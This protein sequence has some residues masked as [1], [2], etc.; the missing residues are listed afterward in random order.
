M[1]TKEFTFGTTPLSTQIDEDGVVWFSANDVCGA[2]GYTNPWKATGDHV[3]ED[4]VTK[5]N[6]IDNMGRNQVASFIN[7]S[8]MYALIFG[9]Q[10]A[11][12]K[13]FKRW[14]TAEVLPAIRKDGG[15]VSRTATTE[16]LTKLSRE[17]ATIREENQTLSHALAHQRA[18]N[19]ALD[20]E[21]R[22]KCSQN[23][24]LALAIEEVPGE[25]LHNDCGPY[26]NECVYSDKFMS[27]LRQVKSEKAQKYFMK[28][29]RTLDTLHTEH[30]KLKAKYNALNL[31]YQ[32]LAR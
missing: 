28:L 1:L 24:K 19:Q 8:G 3:D 2:L 11:E 30:N 21:V 29:G 31:K 4:D 22:E 7:E 15:Y 6:V 16:Q 32:E 13:A 12:A 18:E 25:P 20:L 10:K 23:I 14:V 5:R 17:I 26:P 9:S 27:S